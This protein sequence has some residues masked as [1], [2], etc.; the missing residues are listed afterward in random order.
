MAGLQKLQKARQMVP[1]GAEV[2]PDN[3][4]LF[5]HILTEKLSPAEKAALVRTL[6]MEKQD[7]EKWQKIES[8][9]KKLERDLK[10]AKLQ[11]PSHIYTVLSKA[12]GDQV[13]FLLL[14]SPE[15]LVQDRIKNYLQ[16][17]LPAAL[18]I[19]EREVVAAGGQPGTAKYDKL[20]DELIA[21]RLDARPKK[22]PPPEPAPEVPPAPPPTSAFARR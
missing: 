4:G 1:F 17:Y 12:P 18:E 8:R 16:K 2:H 13:L 6:G 20:R 3:L 5:L 22:V 7:V 11:K 9:S 10:S 15:R 21:T 14:R 19:T